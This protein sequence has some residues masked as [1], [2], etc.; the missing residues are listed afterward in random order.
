MNVLLDDVNSA[1][2]DTGL[3]NRLPYGGNAPIERVHAYVKVIKQIEGVSNVHVTVYLEES[4]LGPEQ[5]RVG[6]GSTP[7]KSDLSLACAP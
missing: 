4:S 5:Q 6:A 3:K 1:L 2:L 7:G